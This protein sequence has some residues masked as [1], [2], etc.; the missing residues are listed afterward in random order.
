MAN[1]HRE[2]PDLVVIR[3]GQSEWNE[4]RLIQG[5][6]NESRL[7]SSG[8][9]EALRA[10]NELHALGLELI[11]TS[12]LARAVE[13]AQ[14]IA[15]VLGL[16]VE[17]DTDLRERSYGVIEGGSLDE[18]TPDLGGITDG[19]VTNEDASPEGGESL[20]ALRERAGRFLRASIVRWPEERLLVVTHGGTVRALRSYAER[21]P[22][23]GMAWDVVANCTTWRV[24]RRFVDS[25]L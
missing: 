2:P 20:R 12:D 10:A 4:R 5:Q 17:I 14:I 18:V 16:G 23:Q 24:P 21:T 13:T 1:D 15:S 8:R 6:N 19:V 25:A 7:T 3:H 9:E 22:L 11:V